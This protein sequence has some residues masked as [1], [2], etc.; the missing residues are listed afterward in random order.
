MRKSTSIMM[1]IV[2]I[3]FGSMMVAANVALKPYQRYAKIG[4]ELTLALGN[5][6]MIREDTKVFVLCRTADEKR[7]AEDGF[8]ML[9]ELAPSESAMGRAGR[10]ERVALRACR[11][12]VRL[13]RQKRDRA[14]DWIEVKLL[15][16]EDTTHRSLIA[17]EKSGRLA[18]PQPAIPATFP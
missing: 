18:R 11:E 3:A 5:L 9:V 6:G 16:S 8:G 4:S 14:L 17:V 10:M 2:L 13:Y 12:A 15:L 1:A 7:L